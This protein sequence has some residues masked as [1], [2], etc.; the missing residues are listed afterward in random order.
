MDFKPN[1]MKLFR[2][3]LDM[4]IEQF[5]TE[6]GYSRRNYSLVERKIAKPSM[7]LIT[8]ISVRFNMKISEVCQLFED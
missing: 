2:V 5:A 1:K 7:R 6:I 4:T 8:A 3:G